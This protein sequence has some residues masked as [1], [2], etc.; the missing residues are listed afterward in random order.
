MPSAIDSHSRGSA[1]RLPL[2][3][4]MGLGDGLAQIC[5]PARMGAF[6]AHLAVG[7]E[8]G[9]VKGANLPPDVLL[10]AVG[11]EGAEAPLVVG[12]GRQLGGRVD[13]QIEALIAVGA[14]AVAHEEVA[15]GHLAQVVLVQ[16][17]AR[18]ALLAEAA[19]P[20]LAHQAV[21]A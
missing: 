15:L 16:E 12:A 8:A 11:T 20:V 13:V 2:T 1:K 4:D 9:Q 6:V 3:L 7:A 5:P 14:V 17:L 18:R 21:E 19:Q 10:G